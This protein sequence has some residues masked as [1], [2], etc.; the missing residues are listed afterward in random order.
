ML[1]ARRKDFK[2]IL[3]RPFLTNE[4]ELRQLL[5]IIQKMTS[6]MVVVLLTV[7]HVETLSLEAMKEKGC[8]YEITT[9]KLDGD[10]IIG[11][12]FPVQ[13]YR[14]NLQKYVLSPQAITWTESFLYAVNQIN[15]QSD[16]LPGVRLG[17]DIRNSCNNEHLVINYTLDYMIDKAFVEEKQKKSA[18]YAMCECSNKTTVAAVVGEDSSHLSAAMSNLL[19]TDYMPQISYRSTSPTLGIKSIYRSFLRTL[20]SDLYQ[21]RAITDLLYTF[22]W[23]YVSV[24]ASDDDYGRQALDNLND[25]MKS[26]NMCMALQRTFDPSFPGNDLNNIVSEI[27]KYQDKS[28][29]VVLWCQVLQAIQIIEKAYDEGLTNITWIGTEISRTDF[30]VLRIQKSNLSVIGITMSDKVVP[31]FLKH[32]KKLGRESP[33]SNPWLE[34][35]WLAL[36]ICP[37]NKTSATF[38][39]YDYFKPS[40]VILPVTGHYNVM[41][42]VYAIGHGL[43]KLLNCKKR[44]GKYTC[45]DKEKSFNYRSLLN[46]IKQVRF[47]IPTTND[48]F[49]FAENG[50]VDSSSYRFAVVTEVMDRG[51]ITKQFRN[52]GEWNGATRKIKFDRYFDTWRINNVA[53]AVC[54]LPCPPGTYIIH[55]SVSCCWKCLECQKDTISTSNNQL[56]CQKCAETQISNTKHTQCVG[57]QNKNLSIHK[58][59]GQ[60]MFAI[61][62]I[63]VFL[64]MFV[65]VT[66]LRYWETPVVKSSSREMSI[67]QLTSIMLLF[68]LPLLF[69][70]DISTPICML[71]TTCFGTLYAQIIAF[72][73]IKTYR[74]LYVFRQTSF[75]KVSKY[76]QNRYQVFISFML[77]LLELIAISVWYTIN[78]P[79]KELLRDEAHKNYIYY[80]GVDEDILL[81]AI[82]G[83]IFF[84]SLVSGFMAFKA[85]S[86][87][88][89]FNEA[90]FIWFGMF[91][92]CLCWLLFIPLYLS[93]DRTKKAIVLLCITMVCNFCLLL[94]LYGYK[95]KIILFNPKLNTQAHFRKMAANVTVTTFLNETTVAGEKRPREQS[96]I[97]FDFDGMFTEYRARVK[98]NSFS[99][100]ARKLTIKLR[101]P[102]LHFPSTNKNKNEV[103]K[104]DNNKR[105][106]MKKHKAKRHKTFQLPKDKVAATMQRSISLDE[107][108]IHR[109]S[110]KN[111][112]AQVQED[113]IYNT[114][115]NSIYHMPSKNMARNV[116]LAST[117]KLDHE[118]AHSKEEIFSPIS[119]N[120]LAALIRPD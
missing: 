44:N 117:S 40:G 45:S 39:C 15:S 82:I 13:G 72:I 110:M 24:L 23:S 106:S 71:Q 120:S 76:L 33:F 28:S 113:N 31:G 95:I 66:F 41:A 63:G 114:A 36:G 27:R 26:K 54:S 83:Y 87:P 97:S 4:K 80:C 84:L 98:Q 116:G 118:V 30:R 115:S 42:A 102:N 88:E 77:V 38:P 73:V 29:V 22:N 3:N 55:S 11:G 9:K 12:I 68:C 103:P 109:L 78:K 50:D 93:L 57:L 99:L 91:V 119:T 104:S 17:Y 94:L 46:N 81:Y 48:T 2:S 75:T 105:K 35:F 70:M 8:D 108:K 47:S 112:E 37:I 18:K 20:P 107:I 64:T 92:T 85:R 100:P 56:K 21:T 79:R 69:M 34:P 74:L 7:S 61:S 53:T 43:H 67:I 49:K 90:Q 51:K 96:V 101:K 5:S 32:K 59:E 60:T 111:I 62:L 16:L 1:V 14:S 25:E 89:N 65:I 10:F 19:S 52:I 58:Y 86:L 6:L